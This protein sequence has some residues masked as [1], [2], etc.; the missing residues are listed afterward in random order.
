MSVSWEIRLDLYESR[1][2]E[3]GRNINTNTVMRM[4]NVLYRLAI[5]QNKQKKKAGKGIKVWREE[6]RRSERE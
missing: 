5:L 6:V 1:F 2:I 3:G 4:E